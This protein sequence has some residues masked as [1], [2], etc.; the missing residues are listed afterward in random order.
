MKNKKLIMMFIASVVAGLLCGVSRVSAQH[1]QGGVDKGEGGHDRSLR[2]VDGDLNNTWKK[3]NSGRV[4]KG[5]KE[6]G[7]D[8]KQM[9]EM[10]EELKRPELSLEQTRE[11]LE[12]LKRIE[13]EVGAELSELYEKNPRQVARILH[14]RFPRVKGF[15]MMKRYDPQMFELR[16]Q[17]IELLGEVRMFSQQYREAVAVGD[18]VLAG[19]LHKDLKQVLELHF[20]VK[21]QVTQLQ[22]DRLQDRLNKMKGAL[23]ER[24]VDKDDLIK[25][26]LDVMEGL[27]DEGVEGLELPGRGM[28]GPN[29]VGGKG[30]IKHGGRMGMKGERDEM[31]EISKELKHV[32]KANGVLG[33]KPE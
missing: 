2:A 16:M 21:T 8:R 32:E 11:T 7:E 19:Q 22:I 20:D 33:N 15:L 24:M 13:P 6:R 31:G 10:Y 5:G 18:D 3:L 23:V 12:L 30:M 14:K 17:E 25:K 4:E 28:M 1:G 27:S 29:G 9:R 26:Q